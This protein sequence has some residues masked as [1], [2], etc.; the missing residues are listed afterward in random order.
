[1]GSVKQRRE[2]RCVVV[3]VRE[4]L[5]RRGRTRGNFYLDVAITD[6]VDEIAFSA[7]PTK[8]YGIDNHS[9]SA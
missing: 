6:D 7:S 3:L 8:S 2:G 1:M 5:V 9:D 4:V